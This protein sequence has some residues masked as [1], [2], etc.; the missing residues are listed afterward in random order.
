MVLDIV[1][2]SDG[3]SQRAASVKLK[4]LSGIPRVIYKHPDEVVFSK[5][6]EVVC[7]N[8]IERVHRCQGRQSQSRE[9]ETSSSSPF[10]LVLERGV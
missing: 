6:E 4:F 7:S 10:E 2:F 3:G 5:L 8:D 1:G 9:G